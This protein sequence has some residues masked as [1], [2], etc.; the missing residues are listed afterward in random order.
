MPRRGH[1]K[2]VGLTD[3]IETYLRRWPA[4]KTF[5]AVD[6]VTALKTPMKSMAR[7]LSYLVRQD[8]LEICGEIERDT[9]KL[10][11]YRLT[12]RP[13]QKAPSSPAKLAEEHDGAVRRAKVG[14][15][16]VRVS[17]G[18]A[19]KPYRETSEARPWRG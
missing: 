15:G 7:A 18:V 12:G 6:M 11:L 2:H 3:T 9:G 17:F 8:Y 1:V 16:R 5:L 19:W 14:D 10:S 13:R 4:E